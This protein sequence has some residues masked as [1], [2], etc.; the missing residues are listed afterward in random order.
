MKTIYSY[1]QSFPN[2]DQKEDFACS[3]IWKGSWERHGW[4]TVMLNKSHAATN[5]LY[6]RLMQKLIKSNLHDQECARYIRWC[7]LYAIG[8]GWMCD[9]DIANLGFSPEDADKVEKQ[10]DLSIVKDENSYL[11][12]ATKGQAEEVIRT[13]TDRDIKNGLNHKLESEILPHAGDLKEILS[14]V[15]HAELGQE[16]TR[17]KQMEE[18]LSE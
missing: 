8:G 1:Y 13:F 7:A 3:N 4:N 16:L 11:F 14:K 17:S 15:F 12:Y 9:Y 18:A 10:C 5:R 2:A 6:P